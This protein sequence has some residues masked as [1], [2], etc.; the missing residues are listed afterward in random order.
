MRSLIL[1]INVSLDGFV[2]TPDGAVEWAF[3]SFDDELQRVLVAELSEA[4]LHAM[5]RV[6]YRDMA[7][8]WP[9][10]D[11]PYAPPMNAIPKLVFSNT[12]TPADLSWGETAIVAG[13]LATEMRAV[14]DVDD[15]KPI[16]AH[17]GAAFA[18]GLSAANLVD[19]YRLYIHPV[20]LGAGVPLFGGPI[21]L[22]LTEVSTFPAGAIRAIYR[23]RS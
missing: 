6:T 22:E 17:G 7:A 15:A 9:T 10:S 21:D 2:A 23:P 5:G 12:L 18:Q 20:A 13:D 1:K 11:E 19:E 8:H 3:E 14:K 16:F 4:G